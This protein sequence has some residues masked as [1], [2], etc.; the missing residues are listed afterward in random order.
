MG[1]PSSR[2]GT[3]PRRDPAAEAALVP[4]LDKTRCS[5]AS[6][7]RAVVAPTSA[8]LLNTTPSTMPAGRQP[9][10]SCARVPAIA[11]RQH[12]RTRDFRNTD[13]PWVRLIL[14]ATDTCSPC[15][16]QRLLSKRDAKQQIHRLS[17]RNP[18]TDRLGLYRCPDWKRHGPAHFHVGHPPTGQSKN[19]RGW[20]PRPI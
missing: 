6:S 19:K 17:R 8:I 18:A 20:Q 2:P 7:V 3:S 1:C 14:M 4:G 12:S 10:P 9:G 13:T 15:G 11:G 16:K 5:R